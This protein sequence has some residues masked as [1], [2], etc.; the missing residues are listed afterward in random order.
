MDP[1][2]LFLGHDVC[3]RICAH[4]ARVGARIALAYPLVVLGWGQAPDGVAVAEAEDAAFLARHEFLDDDL[5]ARRAEFSVEHDLLEGGVGFLSGLGDDDAFAGGE[6]VGLDD[7]VV[8]DAVE[9]LLGQLVV[10]E[11]LVC[12]GGDVVFL[13][14]IL[15]EGLGALHARGRLLGTEAADAGYICA[16]VVDDTG[17]EG[18]LGTGDEEVDVLFVG[19]VV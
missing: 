17:D 7:D 3:R 19:E 9:V 4:A 5:V 10:A 8:V 1:L 6:T 12:G 14:E 15:G 18:G 16:E 13:H 11:V 2:V